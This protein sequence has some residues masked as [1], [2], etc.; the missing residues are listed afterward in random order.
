MYTGILHTHVLSVGL[1]LVLYL[2]KTFLLVTGKEE[3]LEKVTKITKHPERLISVLFLAT[4]IYLLMNSGNVTSLVYIKIAMVFASIPLAV[5]GFKRK[6]SI[7]AIMSVVLLLLSYG[8]AEMNGKRGASMNKPEQDLS[9][10]NEAEVG[11]A[12]YENYCQNCHGPNGDAG[13]S[14]AK[15]LRVTML[16]AEEQANIIS[17]GKGVMPGF[18]NLNSNEVQAIVKHVQGL[19]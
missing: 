19:K 6:K 2:V 14:G 9:Q 10:A 4:G 16:S 8:L 17:N 1:F 12:L 7:L 5:I 15:N 18:K 11:K 13:L 3:A